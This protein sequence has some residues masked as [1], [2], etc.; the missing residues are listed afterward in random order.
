MSGSLETTDEI[1][2]TVVTALEDYQLLSITV[3]TENADDP[4]AAVKGLVALHLNWT[5]ENR[6][7]ATLIARHRNEVAAGP[8]S[9]RLMASNKE[10][11]AS[12]KTWIDR[13][14]ENGRMPPVSFNLMHA[15]TFAPTQEIAKLA[16]AGRLKKPLP[17]YAEALGNAAWAG[18]RALPGRQRDPVSR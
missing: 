13:Q 4:E 12:M 11:F 14:S 7:T 18:L 10:Y 5:E 6:E 8:L 9:E 1:A 3:V 15:V 16:I 17:E 2:E